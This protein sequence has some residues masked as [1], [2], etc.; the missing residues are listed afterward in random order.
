[1][2][3]TGAYYGH[4]GMDKAA[5]RIFKQVAEKYSKTEW[6][7]IAVLAEAVIYDEKIK[8]KL[9][10]EELYQKILDI[11]PATLEG[12]YVRQNITFT[13]YPNSSGN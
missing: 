1:M 9:K 11:Y 10:A 5:V 8:D 4:I 3:F 6:G 2:L 12:E 13:R 7:Q